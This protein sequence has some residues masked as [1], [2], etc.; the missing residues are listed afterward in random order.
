[1]TLCASVHDLQHWAVVLFTEW[2][3]YYVTMC[4]GVHDLQHWV[5]VLLCNHVCRCA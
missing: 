3:W 4:I 2:Q 5:V 1:M